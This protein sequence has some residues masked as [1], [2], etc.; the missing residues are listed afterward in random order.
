ME[1]TNT[2]EETRADIERGVVVLTR[3]DYRQLLDNSDTEIVFRAYIGS[4]ERFD[5]D[6]ELVKFGGTIPPQVCVRELSFGP[7]MTEYKCECSRY[8]VSD[9]IP[10]LAIEETLE[11]RSVENE[12]TKIGGE[13]NIVVDEYEILQG[14]EL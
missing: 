8:E 12:G 3:D 9:E 11:S 5:T 7:Y 10:E 13:I 4:G 1:K 6:G 2:V 14:D